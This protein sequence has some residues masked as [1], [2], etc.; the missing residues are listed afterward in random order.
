MDA[1]PS[2]KISS[3]VL[4]TSYMNETAPESSITGR[5]QSEQAHQHVA[6]R[7]AEHRAAEPERRQQH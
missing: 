6:Q 3:I 1:A 4:G 7:P 2:G 5:I